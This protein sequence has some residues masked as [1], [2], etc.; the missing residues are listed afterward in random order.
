MYGH[1]KC[2]P[3]IVLHSYALRSSP[4]QAGGR[5]L[6]ADVEVDPGRLAE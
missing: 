2:V 3:R 4:G 1:N 5:E 6:D